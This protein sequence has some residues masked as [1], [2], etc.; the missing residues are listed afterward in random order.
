[1][2]MM[3][4]GKSTTTR[5]SERCERPVHTHFQNRPSATRSHARCRC[6]QSTRS[7]A[8]GSKSPQLLEKH[9]QEEFCTYCSRVRA[10]I[11]FIRSPEP[12]G[13][14]T[15]NQR[16]RSH[17]GSAFASRILAASVGF[18]ETSHRSRDFPFV[19]RQSLG[20]SASETSSNEVIWSAFAS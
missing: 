16:L 11:P 10:Y 9:F 17:T 15:T 3:A 14:R 18:S 8:N 19:V 2:S 12:S 13:H 4:C 1:M 6:P 7:E 5:P 20:A